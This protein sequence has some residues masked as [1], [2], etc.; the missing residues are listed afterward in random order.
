MKRKTLLFLA[1]AAVCGGA[2]AQ[3][4][5]AAI[6]IMSRNRLGKAMVVDTSDVR[7]YYALNADTLS[8]QD[9]YVDLR[10]LEV[11]KRVTK[12]SSE[13]VREGEAHQQEVLKS[14]K[15]A[16]PHAD[17]VPRPCPIHG[18]RSDYW[19][20]IQYTDIYIEGQTATEYHTMPHGFQGENGY[21]TSLYPSQKWALTNE[22]ATVLGHRCQQATCHWRGRDFIAWF[23]PDI[24]IRRGP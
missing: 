3:Q 24:P 22:T 15:V 6:L 5:D 13:F 7:I 21:Q 2:W 1:L 18:K 17:G 4:K 16:H 19:N 14:W 10:V 23:A 8:N 9:T 11:G 20:E 12:C